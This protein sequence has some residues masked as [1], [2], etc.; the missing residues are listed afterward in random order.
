MLLI[1]RRYIIEPIKIGHGLS[2]G[3]VFDQFFGAA[4]EQ[5]DMRID[6]L[7]DFAVEFEHK[8]QHAVGRRMLRAKVDRK[9]AP[10]FR[11]RIGKVVSHQPVSSSVFAFSSPGKLRGMPSQGER[12]SKLR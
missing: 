8:A 7:D 10:L 5:A 4:M 9:G 2:V 3:F 6:A 12:K 11:R 1:H